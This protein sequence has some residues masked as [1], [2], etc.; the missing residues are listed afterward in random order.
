MIPFVKATKRIKYLRINL[1][2]A[3][4]LYAENY[5]ALLQELRK[6]QTNGK[7]FLVHGLEDLILLKYSPHPKQS[8][9]SVQ[10]LAK[11]Q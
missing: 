5:K 8:T 10:S 11:S 2:E 9:D 1:K 3:K 6:T 4:D 7:T